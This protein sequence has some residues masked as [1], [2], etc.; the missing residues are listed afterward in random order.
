MSARMLLSALALSLT[1]A[2][3]VSMATASAGPRG[4]D[5][6]LDAAVNS[7]DTGQIVSRMKELARDDP[8]S[9]A[10]YVAPAFAAIEALTPSQ[11]SD[12]DRYRVFAGALAALLR[13]QDSSAVNALKREFN[14]SK[15][16]RVRFIILR[17]SW[18]H[19]KMD[20]ID[21]SLRAIK[22]KAPQLVAQAARILGKSKKTEAIRPVLDAMTKWETREHREKVHVGRKQVSAEVGGRAWIACRDAMNRLTGQ[23]FHSASD[24][25]NYVKAHAGKINPATVDVSEKTTTER[26]TGIGLFGLDLSGRN[27]IFILDIS[28]SME[29]TDPFTPEQL[30]EL[31]RPG[32]TW[33]GDK[34]PLEEEMLQDR[35]RILRAKK[36]L[37]KVVR[38]LP[39]G[40]RFNLII[41]SNETTPWKDLLVD[42]SPKAKAEAEKFID[43]I[44]AHG[45]TFT[46]EALRTALEDPS[47]DTV[48]LITDGAPTHM[49]SRG[50]D[51]PPDAKQLMSDILS[52]TKASNYLRGVRIFTLGFEGAEEGF[53]KQL[54]EEHDGKYVR[55]R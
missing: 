22:D 28:G 4:G 34:D 46:D 17:A 55:I 16:W 51:L 33:V 50:K 12:G 27:L 48:Y 7:R 31:N 23:S 29:S 25:R 54:A 49:G 52:E 32:R 40:R 20:A 53:L 39:E 8:K 19:G 10:K 21:L 47:V 11:I 44:K 14:K 2:A 5:A 30:A 37:M 42:V 35:K 15:D 41:Y 13:I 26:A 1:L 3:A 24:Y 43:Q 6:A 45:V 38:S 36:E 9:A 18:Q